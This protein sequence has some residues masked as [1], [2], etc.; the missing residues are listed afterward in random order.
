[1]DKDQVRWNK[2]VIDFHFSSIRFRRI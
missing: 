2:Y 1:M